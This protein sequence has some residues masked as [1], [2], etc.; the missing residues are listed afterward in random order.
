[1]LHWGLTSSP[2][3]LMSRAWQGEVLDQG[4]SLNNWKRCCLGFAAGSARHPKASS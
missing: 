4:P 3:L 1:M 2:V